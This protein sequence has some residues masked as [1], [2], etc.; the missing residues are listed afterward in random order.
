MPDTLTLGGSLAL[1]ATVPWITPPVRG[2]PTGPWLVMDARRRHALRTDIFL[3]ALSGPFQ[4]LHGHDRRPGAGRLTPLWNWDAG[5]CAGM[6]HAPAPGL[7]FLRAQRPGTLNFRLAS[8]GGRRHSAEEGVSHIKTLL[9]FNHEQHHQTDIV[10]PGP[11]RL[12]RVPSLCGV[13]QASC[14]QTH[15]SCMRGA[16][17]RPS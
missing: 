8:C 7:D 12:R 3:G 2:R 15:S 10:R 11:G 14:E 16:S 9:P 4:F 17:T 5:N 6:K 1:D 13:S